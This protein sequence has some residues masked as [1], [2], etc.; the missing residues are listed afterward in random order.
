M[1]NFTKKAL[2]HLIAERFTECYVCMVRGYIAEG[3]SPET[4]PIC[5]APQFKFKKVD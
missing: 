1:L 2:D 3:K 4:C 5:N